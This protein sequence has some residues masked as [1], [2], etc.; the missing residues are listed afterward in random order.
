M[1]GFVL[2]TLVALL[3]A[4]PLLWRIDTELTMPNQAVGAA[5]GESTAPSSSLDPEAA[6]RR[7]AAIPRPAREQRPSAR[8]DDPRALRNKAPKPGLISVDRPASY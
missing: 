8:P 3:L 2:P 1:R 4:A 6:A 5:T 7:L